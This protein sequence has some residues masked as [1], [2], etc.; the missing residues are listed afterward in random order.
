MFLGFL[1]SPWSP[2]VQN[3]RYFLG[4]PSRPWLLI[5]VSQVKIVLTHLPF[6][7]FLYFVCLY[8]RCLFVHFSYFSYFPGASGKW[9]CLVYE[10]SVLCIVRLANLLCKRHHWQNSHLTSCLTVHNP[11]LHFWAVSIVSYILYFLVGKYIGGWPRVNFH[12]RTFS[13]FV[14]FLHF[15]GFTG[16]L[17]GFGSATTV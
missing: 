6:Q 3:V 9:K 8:F 17:G 5:N 11:I 10:L 12:F 14:H 4:L 13:G 15:W 16:H 7:A 2:C 1:G